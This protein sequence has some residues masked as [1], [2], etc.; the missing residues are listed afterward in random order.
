MC[1]VNTWC[2][3]KALLPVRGGSRTLQ[4]EIKYDARRMFNV[5][6]DP[7]FFEGF[8]PKDPINTLTLEVATK[9]AAQL[10]A[11]TDAFIRQALSKIV[12]KDMLELFATS[13]GAFPG[14]DLEVLLKSPTKRVLTVRF[15]GDDI[16]HATFTT[17]IIDRDGD[18]V[19]IHEISDVKI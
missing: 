2:W 16:G 18:K 1:A 15:K 9:S 10:A 4:A 17:K 7:R 3:S 8:D 5:I 6:Q 14:L 11:Q 13:G 19:V 12:S